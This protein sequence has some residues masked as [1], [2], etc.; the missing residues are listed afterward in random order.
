[1]EPSDV[2]ERFKRYSQAARDNCHY[3]SEQAAIDA[4]TITILGG[5]IEKFK[6]Y[7]QAARDNCNNSSKQVAIDTLNMA[8]MDS[9]QSQGGLI[10]RLLPPT[11][12]D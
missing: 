4:L 5:D 6:N 10:A 7:H 8:L 2:I 9:I 1:M 3:S 12:K 11:P